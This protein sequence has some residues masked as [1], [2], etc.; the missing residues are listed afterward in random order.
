MTKAFDYVL[1]DRLLLKLEHYGIRGPAYSWLESYIKDRKQRVE[2]LSLGKA[3]TIQA[4]KSQFKY[5]KLG[6][7]QGSVL[8]PLLFLI[9]INDLPD[10]TT[11]RS[12]LFADDISIIVSTRKNMTLAKHLNDINNTNEAVINWL[13][14]NNLTV[15]FNKTMYIN[16]NRITFDIKYNGQPLCRAKHVTF[17]GNIIDEELKWKEHIQKVCDK[18]N[19]FSYA[20]FKLNRVATRQTAMIAYFSYVESVLRYGLL[21]WGNSPDINKVFI[22]QKRCIRAIYNV[23]PQT[24]CKPLFKV[25]GILP[26]PCLYILEMAKFIKQNLNDIYGNRRN[27]STAHRANRFPSK[28]ITDVVPKTM[29][30]QK[31]CYWMGKTIFNKLP[32][33]IKE[34]PLLKFKK[35]LREYLLEHRFY[36]VKE[37]LE[38]KFTF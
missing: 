25:L 5:N 4:Y 14:H 17:L 35:V 32:Q 13:I 26:L 23:S 6:V 31:N 38:H 22:V 7:P 28:I 29:G 9:Y 1:H 27:N 19:R 21:L 2:V 33:R 18:I 15:N 37:F 36:S 11:F 20:L 16:F 24:S 30:F 12:I 10:Y 8:G 34:Q 3:N